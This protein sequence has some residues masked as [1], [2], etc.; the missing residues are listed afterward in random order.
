[1]AKRSARAAATSQRSSSGAKRPPNAGA[2]KPGNPYRWKPGQSGNPAG[3]KGPKLSDLLHE[4]LAQPMPADQGQ[5]L[6]D[7]IESGATIGQIIAFAAGLRAAV[8]DLEALGVIAD[9][10]EGAPD[11][12]VHI[13]DVTSDELARARAHA[14]QWERERFPEAQGE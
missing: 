2:F 3:T 12:T 5:A 11:Q 9:R 6:T 13:A 8:G 10:T 4:M 1:M 14:E 7:L